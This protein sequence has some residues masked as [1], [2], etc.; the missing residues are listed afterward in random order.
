[1]A[2]RQV[3]YGD[4]ALDFGEQ[5]IYSS[6]TKRKR[7][8]LVHKI[9]HLISI[10]T[11]LT[12]TALLGACENS[13]KEQ[14]EDAEN[15]RNFPEIG[16]AVKVSTIAGKAV[17][18]GYVDGP[19]SDARFRLPRAM[20]SDGKN[21][22]IVEPWNNI[23]R[24]IVIAT[25]EVSTFAGE[26]RNSNYLD[27]IGTDARL[28]SPNSITILNN[29]IYFGDR[30]TVRSI[31]IATQEVTTI[32]GAFSIDAVDGVDGIGSGAR[33]GTIASMTNDGTSVFVAESQSRNVRK[34]NVSTNEVTTLAY[35]AGQTGHM[36]EILVYDDGYL[37]LVTSRGSTS[38]EKINSTTGAVTTL[39]GPWSYIASDPSGIGG[40]N[41]SIITALT[42]Q[43]EYFYVADSGGLVRRINI[44]SGDELVLAG[45]IGD[46][47]Y[48]DGVGENARFWRF[49]G[50]VNNGKYLFVSDDL[51]HNVR[52]IE[53]ATG[54][55][56]TLA[57]SGPGSDDGIGEAARFFK[58]YDVTSDGSNLYV[59]DGSNSTIR[60]ISLITGSVTT[61]AGSARQRGYD[62]GVGAAARFIQIRGITNDGTHLYVAD[63]N[64]IRKVE[65]STGT[66]TTLAGQK[67]FGT[68]IDG[69]GEQAT[70]YYLHGITTDGVYLY[71]VESAPAI[72]RK[73]H[74]VTGE[75]TTLAG[76]PNVTGFVDGTG[77][78]AAFASPQYI[79]TDGTYLYVTDWN[80]HA[81]RKIE[82]DTGEVTTLDTAGY[83]V[84]PKG[85]VLNGE[86]LY[87]VNSHAIQKI[88]TTSGETT[89]IAGGLN[90]YRDGPGNEALFNSPEGIALVGSDLYVADT[91]NH[92]IRRIENLD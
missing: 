55:V 15:N 30:N 70:L 71:V 77:A 3:S 56:T 27:G 29:K 82:I 83:L 75:V 48:H 72:I 40:G 92:V 91:N 65:I 2:T 35:G 1:M 21:L 41:G 11:L 43:N 73:V 64:R 24:K 28:S 90:D 87:V 4:L 7:I 38:I 25:G 49:D 61:L 53:I 45:K 12:I 16:N 47:A 6:F 10:S 59:T 66:V 89:T 74:S 84:T 23:I 33:F 42:K 37:Y 67:S 85:I 13:A 22:Y 57:G 46:H 5:G 79:T 18:M 88:S 39:S 78:D 68:S 44:N 76:T 32:A 81:I 20:A 63:F 36:A 58:P 54:T 80:N 52:Q 31:D 69:I 86:T 51:L 17:G 14:N 60:K 9:R 62:D 8:Y 50:M 19:G 26:A 34:I